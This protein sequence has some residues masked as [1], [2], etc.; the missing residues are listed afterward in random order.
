LYN[1]GIG[2]SSFLVIV[3]QNKKKK[4]IATRQSNYEERLARHWC[5]PAAIFSTSAI[6]TFYGEGL[7]F[8][9]NTCSHNRHT[10][11][12]HKLLLDA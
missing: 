4:V 11:V 2:L 5:S 10:L 7:A 3:G 8:I 1:Y 6:G 9:P 12:Y